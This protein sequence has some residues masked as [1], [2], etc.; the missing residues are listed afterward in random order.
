LKLI[1]FGYINI[2]REIIENNF[3]FPP[4]FRRPKAS[5]FRSRGVPGR[6]DALL[7]KSLDYEVLCLLTS[8]GIEKKYRNSGIDK[9]VLGIV[10][11]LSFAVSPTTIDK[12][13]KSDKNKDSASTLKCEI[14][15]TF[16][17]S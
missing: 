4:E 16:R 10:S 5:T 15:I 6:L 11:K 7:A 3:P 9:K 17:F 8:V 13:S 2:L 1:R 14:S 12:H